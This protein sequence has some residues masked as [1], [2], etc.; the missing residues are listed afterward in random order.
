MVGYGREKEMKRRDKRRQKENNEGETK[1]IKRS[2]METE[3]HPENDKD[4]R[5]EEEEKLTKKIRKEEG[6]GAGVGRPPPTHNSTSLCS[7]SCSIT[8]S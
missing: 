7:D 4:W 8:G 6:V 1:Q 3:E 2:K 5:R